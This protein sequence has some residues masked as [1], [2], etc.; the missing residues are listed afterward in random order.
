MGVVKGK[1]NECDGPHSANNFSLGKFRGERTPPSNRVHQARDYFAKEVSDNNPHFLSSSASTF[2]E[3][4]AHEQR[5]YLHNSLSS[6]IEKPVDAPLL[7]LGD[8]LAAPVS[9]VRREGPAFDRR[10]RSPS[11]PQCQIPPKELLGSN[12]GQTTAPRDT[13]N[14]STAACRFRLGRCSLPAS[15]KKYCRV[16]YTTKLDG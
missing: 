13:I 11:C 6:T 10:S 7:P 9:G 4:S 8:I 2:A 1:A 3:Y 5:A 15:C 14:C 12:W 16:T